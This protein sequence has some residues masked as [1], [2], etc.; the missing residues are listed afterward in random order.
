MHQPDLAK[1]AIGPGLRKLRLWP[2]CHA[3]RRERKTGDVRAQKS[4]L[5]STS[6]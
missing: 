3:P 2:G 4:T 5:E 6:K 1:R